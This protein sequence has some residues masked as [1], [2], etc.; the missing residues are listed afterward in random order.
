MA[1]YYEVLG[2]PRNADP[3]E[4]KKAYRKNAVKYHPDKNPGN[5]DAE[6]RFKEV[7]E[8]YEVLGNAEKRRVYD[9]YGAEAVRGGFGG[10]AA[11]AGGFASMEDALRTFMNA[12]GGMGGSIFESFFGFDT[13]AQEG[14]ARQGA[15]KKL[16]L[17]L[18]FEEAMRGVEKE[19]MIT[20]L[21]ACSPCDGKGA[22]SVNDI[23]RCTRCHGSGQLHQTHGFFSMA[24]M[25]ASCGGKG[26]VIVTPCKECRGE[27]RIKQKQPLTIKVPAGVD[28]GMRMKMSSCGDVGA[29]GGPAGDLYIHITVQPHELFQRD[30]DDILLEIPLSFTE[31]ALG[32]KKELP[33]PTGGSCRLTIP[34]GTQAGKLFR[35]KGEG[36]PNVHHQGKGDLLVRILVETPVSLSEKQK[37]LLR[38]FSELERDHNSPR[39][40]TFWDKLKV[41][42]SP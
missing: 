36:A 30:G 1:D 28:S 10:G 17:T 33:T 29:G 2:I 22:A 9:Q 20:R 6:K 40:Q 25:C 11:E 34:E 4:I 5:P 3:D 42:F 18:S 16:Q 24:T 27:G 41:F 19:V 39:K 35:I 7:S 12:F 23:K 31:A 13:E 21:V 32:C 37:E 26:K 15:S 8:A 38:T 14:Q